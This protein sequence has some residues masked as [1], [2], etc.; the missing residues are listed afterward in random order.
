MRK[1]G[2]EEMVG[3]H[4]GQVHVASCE[5][6]SRWI[7]RAVEGSSELGNGDDDEALD[8]VATAAF[9]SPTTAVGLDAAITHAIAHLT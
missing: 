6:V 8:E 7:A 4:H 3:S 2:R 1:V 5:G 9:Y